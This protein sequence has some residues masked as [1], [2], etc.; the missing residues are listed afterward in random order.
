[1][2]LRRLAASPIV[3][4]TALIMALGS[5]DAVSSTPTVEQLKQLVRDVREKEDTGIKSTTVEF[6]TFEVGRRVK[7]NV[8]MVH[9]QPVR[10]SDA[11][12][13]GAD[14]YPI[15]TRMI[16]TKVSVSGQVYSGQVHWK[17]HA[18]IS[19]ARGPGKDAWIAISVGPAS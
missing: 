11:A 2:V 13:I 18:F 5:S 3:F 8:T 7:N 17:Y 9:G 6:K 16:I 1:M 12:P 10:V 4:V 15:T 14:I 19:E